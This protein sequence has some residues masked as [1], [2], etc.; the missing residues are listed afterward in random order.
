MDREVRPG[1][2]GRALGIEVIELP[3]RLTT[4][5]VIAAPTLVVLLCWLFVALQRSRTQIREAKREAKA[6]VE[7]SVRPVHRLE[8]ELGVLL[9]FFQVFSDLL[10]ELHSERRLRALP[11]LM[12]NAMVRVYRPEVA[13]VLVRRQGE[14][15]GFGKNDRLVVAALSS[16][17]RRLQVGMEFDIGEGQVGIVAEQQRMMVREDFDVERAWRFELSRQT[18]EPTYDLVAPMVVGGEA[19]GV[20]AI[21]QPERHHLREKEMMEMIARIGALTWKNVVAFQDVKDVADI[22][23]L[24]G[25]LNKGALLDR[26]S[27]VVMQAREQGVPA[28]VFMFDLD[29]FKVYND[30]NGHLAGD[31][32]LKTLAGLVKD[33]VRAE[34][35]FGRFGGEEF[36]LVMPGLGA[37]QAMT[38]AGIVRR[39]IEEYPFEGEET[40]PMGRVTISGGV[41]SFPADAPDSVELLRAADAALYRGKQ[42]GRNLVT[43][44]GE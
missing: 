28:S 16:S 40:Q 27:T 42:G 38:A 35:V 43:R 34:D 15:G 36:L 22:D 37:A 9:D 26:L 23:K 31:H 5:A 21:G 1:L 7:S 6:A 41:A 8:Q 20:L 30:T 24:T 3:E 19:L 32:L 10:G 11:Q 44:A 12:L 29:H 39:R 2:V 25:I 14:S 4:I 33:N 18:K 13:V 17:Q